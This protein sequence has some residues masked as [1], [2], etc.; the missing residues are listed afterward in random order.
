MS[1]EWPPQRGNSADSRHFLTTQA[2][3]LLCISRDPEARLRDVAASVGITERRAQGIVSTL[4]E[5]GF[6]VRERVGR[7]N[8]YTVNRDR[9]IYDPLWGEHE[10]GDILNIA[11]RSVPRPASRGRLDGARSPGNIAF[12]L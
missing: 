12:G 10:V 4:V 7:R 1:A 3:V 11:D 9:R 5:A 2:H 6:L 8:R